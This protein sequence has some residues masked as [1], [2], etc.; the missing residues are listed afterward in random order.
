MY[1][2]AESGSTKCDW[3]LV[4]QQGNYMD[5]YKTIGFNPF[6]HS[7]EFICEEINNEKGLIHI[8]PKVKQLYFYGAG[9]SS[10]HYKSIVQSALHVIFPNAQIEVDHDMI[11]AAYS[12]YDGVPC[13][14]CIIGTGS[15]SCFFDGENVTEVVPALAYILGD[16][17]SG[18]YFGKRLL[19]DFLYKKLPSEIHY[20]LE[21][22]F[23]LSKASIF[24]RV[25]EKPHANV[26]L[27]GF[28]RFIG[29]YKEHPYIKAILIQGMRDFLINHVCCYPNY[30]NTPVHFVG[31]VAF[32][33]EEE[34]RIA[35]KEF[36]IKIGRI[37]K[38]P[39]KNL[40]DYHVKYKFHKQ[41]V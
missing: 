30:L 38:Q 39:I 24:E 25:Y 4:D 36:N 21:K 11:S 35:A 17:G 12:T 13:I 26:Y 40:V 6:F 2:I 29:Q 31:S 22:E 28:T 37:I 9:C 3:M 15:N 18:S 19:T 5:L 10:N 20:D 14:S 27:A 23:N 8:A 32:H 7:K 33:F 34:L 41:K 1:L 16:E